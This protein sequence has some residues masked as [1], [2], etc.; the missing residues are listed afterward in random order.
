MVNGAAN[1]RYGGVEIH[2]V[3]HRQFELLSAK[4]KRATTLQHVI[5]FLPLMGVF[6]RSTRFK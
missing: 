2:G 5:E 6:S 1:M 3:T 4:V